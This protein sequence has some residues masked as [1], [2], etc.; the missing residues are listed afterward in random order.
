MKSEITKTGDTVVLRITGYLDFESTLP[1]QRSLDQIYAADKNAKVV[2]DMQS[3]E[4]VGSS[5]VAN[6]VKGMKAFNQQSIRPRFVGVK[7]EFLRLFRAF[8]ADQPFD[9][10]SVVQQ[11]VSSR[12]GFIDE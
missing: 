10:G 2:V 9:I 12:A 5:G 8:E 4:F 7:S 6:F 3:L 11:K 1:L